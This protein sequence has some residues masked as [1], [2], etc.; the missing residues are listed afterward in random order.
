MGKRKI[1]E[2]FRKKKKNQ[3][4][5]RK[6]KHQLI[7]AHKKELAQIFGDAIFQVGWPVSRSEIKLALGIEEE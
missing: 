4:R 7:K 6:E 5:R 1:T 2:Y 3:R